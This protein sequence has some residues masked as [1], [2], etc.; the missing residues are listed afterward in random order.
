MAPRAGLTL[1]ALGLIFVM[2]SLLASRFRDPGVA[3][4]RRA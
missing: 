4:I 2:A 1:I 3:P